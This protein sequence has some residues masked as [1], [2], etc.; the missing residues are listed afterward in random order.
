MSIWNAILF[1]IV[2]GITEFVPVSSSAHLA[3]M[4][5]LFG[6]TGAGFNSKMFSVFLHFGTVIAAIVT[7]W[8]DFGELIFQTFDIAAESSAENAAAP[9]LRGK[10]A[11]GGRKT[12][13][14]YPGART[15]LMMFF[16]SLPLAM[17]LPINGKISSLSDSSLLVGI[18][19]LISGTILFKA[20]QFREGKKS[21]GTMTVSDA[22][23]I[24]L[25]QC[26][27]A[28]PGLSRTGVVMSAGMATGVRADFAAKFAVMMS[29]PVMFIANFVRIVDA[30]SLGFSLS[31]LPGCLAGMAAALA[32]GYFSLKILMGAVKRRDFSWFSYYSWVAGVIFII[33]TMI[34]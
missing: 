27:S 3:V 22:V 5:N 10:S 9:S 1:G 6:I 16:A 11:A 8:R 2:Q 18:M 15:L 14:V 12:R 25:C 4:F 20:G 19:L 29:V 24:G 13:K 21:A 7:Y 32:A 28:I 26:A 33:L 30:A 31:E 17:I 34:F 23:I